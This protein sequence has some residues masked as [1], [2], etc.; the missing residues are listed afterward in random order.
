MPMG[1]RDHEL[2][3]FVA[4]LLAGLTLWCPQPCLGAL[5][6][7]GVGGVMLTRVSGGSAR[8]LP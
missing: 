7:A 4:Q 6:L 5:V 3:G 2:R 1:S 8:M